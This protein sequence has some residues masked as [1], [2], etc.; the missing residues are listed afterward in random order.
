[1]LGPLYQAMDPEGAA[2]AGGFT[3]LSL[4]ASLAKMF[5]GSSTIMEYLSLDFS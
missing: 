2:G 4:L 5:L 1:M 3:W